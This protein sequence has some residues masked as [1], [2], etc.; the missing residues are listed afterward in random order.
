MLDR[1]QLKIERK[2]A[3]LGVCGLGYVGLPVACA[4]AEAGFDVLGIETQGQRVI[5]VNS[6]NLPIGGQEPGLAE[7]LN[8]VVT[9]GK[10]KATTDHAQLRD[11][12]IILV[13]VETPIDENHQ[14]KFTALYQALED[15]GSALKSGSLVI[16]ESTLAPGTLEGTVRPLLE[17]AAG[18]TANHDFFLG[19]CP[20]RLTSGKLLK[21][22]RTRPRVVGGLTPRTAEVAADLYRH[23]VEADLHCTDSVTAEMVKTVENAERDVQIAFANEVALICESAG[24]DV[25]T[26]RTLV[27]ES[28]DRNMLVPGAGVGGHCIPKDPWLLA[29]S[30]G[31]IPVS[32][33]PA[34]RKINDAMPFHMLELVKAALANYEKQLRGTRL[35]IM[36]FA[37]RENTDDSRNS[38]SRTLVAEIEKQGAE[39]VVH[40][41]HVAG[42]VRDLS[43]LDQ[44][45]FDAA[46]FMVRHDRY[47]LIN[48]QS[49]K[50]LLIQPVVIDGRQVFDAEKMAAA[51]FSYFAIGQPRNKPLD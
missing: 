20:E 39:V 41:P 19:V 3:L 16:V 23:V 25:R 5:D 31:R 37:Y 11:R 32:L 47:Q 7:L 43:Q 13:C 6:A 4:F 49:L 28:T 9:A 22:L 30:A 26:V 48:L 38:P 1:L 51:G 2:E 17:R 27:N 33:I 14:P 46:L 29:F 21:N 35:L 50:Q 18:K 12:D 10:L 34:A 40:D 44:Q 15:I 45:R 8:T 42:C 24:C 36:G